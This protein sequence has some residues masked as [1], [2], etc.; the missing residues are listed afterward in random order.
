[1][2]VERQ[3]TVTLSVADATELWRFISLA[4]PSK[5]SRLTKPID[6]Q[7]M[8]DLKEELGRNLFSRDTDE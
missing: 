5:F 2:L 3:L 4:T 8:D 6:W 1:M 7:R